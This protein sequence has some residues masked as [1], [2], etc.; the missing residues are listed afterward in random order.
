M[1]ALAGS[2]PNM[3][4]PHAFVWLSLATLVLLLDA[5]TNDPPGPGRGG[6]TGM[7]GAGGSGARAGAGGSGGPGAAGGAGGAAPSICDGEDFSPAACPA[8]APYPS[9]APTY[10]EQI[11]EGCAI[12][13]QGFYGFSFGECGPL[14]VARTLTDDG[15]GSSYWCF[16]DPVNEQVAGSIFCTDIDTPDCPNVFCTR[17]GP[18]ALC[19]QRPPSACTGSE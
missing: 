4:R 5:C 3:R 11:H 17:N 19:C 7:A 13:Q 18:V 12:P 9:C 16:Y 6:T 14:L 2:I 1:D 8:S 10:A 15:L